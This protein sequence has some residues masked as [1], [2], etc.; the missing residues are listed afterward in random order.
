MLRL[1]EVPAGVNSGLIPFRPRV[2]LDCLSSGRRR[3]STS[4]LLE[5]AMRNNL[6]IKHDE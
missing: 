4:T 1:S 6:P 3:C 5:I 2:L